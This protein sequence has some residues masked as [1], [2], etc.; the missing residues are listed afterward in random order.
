MACSNLAAGPPNRWRL[1][2][3]PAGDVEPV[4]GHGRRHELQADRQS[5]I[6]ESHRT[7]I[8]GIPAR[9]AGIVAM[10]C[11]HAQG[12]IH[13]LTERKGGRR[14]GRRARTSACEKAAAKSLAMRSAPSAPARSRRRSN[15]WTARRSRCMIAA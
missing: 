10:S 1:P 2:V 5:L 15:R 7:D 8:P 4:V 11:R 6:V 12:V 13:L 9:L 14:G 3:L